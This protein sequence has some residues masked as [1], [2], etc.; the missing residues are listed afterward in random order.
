MRISGIYK[1]QSRIKPERVYI[2]SAGNIHQRFAEHRSELKNHKHDNPKLQRHCDKYGLDDLEFSIITGCSKETLIAYEQFYFDALDP[3]FNICKKA[4]SPLGRAPW[5]K[6]KT[7]SNEHKRNIGKSMEGERNSMYGKP[8]PIKGMKGKYP[9]KYKGVKGR[10]SEET[11]A[12]MRKSNKAAWMKRKQKKEELC[13]VSV[14]Q[15]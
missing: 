11:L 15:K 4:G 10:Y 3:Y 2:G 9:N 8:A 6:G 13:P 14:Q 7:L 1:I 5:N 12:K